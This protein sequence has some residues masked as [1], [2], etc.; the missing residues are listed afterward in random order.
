[1]IN[2]GNADAIGVILRSRIS[3][4]QLARIMLSRCLAGDIRWFKLM[5][6]MTEDPPVSL[7]EPEEI[8]PESPDS[9]IDPAVIERMMAVYDELTSVAVADAVPAARPDPPSP[10]PPPVK[11][12]PSTPPGPPAPART[13][14]P[15]VSK[16]EWL[17]LHPGW[18]EAGADGQNGKK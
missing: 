15:D 16:A 12:G 4:E 1:M 2:D 14:P 17:R 10:P 18:T 8:T 9:T 3:N 11:H 5:L 6:E 13:R 7:I